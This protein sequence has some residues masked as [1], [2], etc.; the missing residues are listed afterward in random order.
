MEEVAHKGAM[1]LMEV[2]S[3]LVTPKLSVLNAKARPYLLLHVF[4]NMK[5][6][7]GTLY[8]DV[9]CAKP[10]AID[11]LVIAL[12]ALEHTPPEAVPQN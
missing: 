2:E 10:D 1:G 7:Q 12:Q 9:G 4:E 3:V 5:G 6:I 11:P 8:G